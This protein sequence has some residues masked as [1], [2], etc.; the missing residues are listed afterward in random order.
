MIR[1]VDIEDSKSL[2][3]IYNYYVEKTIITFDEEPISADYMEG[4]IEEVQTSKLPWLVAEENNKV[5]GYAYA[6]KWK[7]RC[8]YRF[9]VEITIYLDQNFKGKGFGT[10]LY[11]A[12]F[13]EL[14]KTDMH[15]AIGGIS[16]PNPESIKLHEKFGMEKVAHFKEVGY[17]FNEWIDVGYWQ[18]EI[19]EEMRRSI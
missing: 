6:S 2:S 7:G 1:N 3:D 12:L 15:V 5:I 10:K 9:S 8:S 4:Q 14:A 16:L 11:Q 13:D 17:K 19:K 18:R